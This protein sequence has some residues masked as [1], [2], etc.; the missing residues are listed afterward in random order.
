MSENYLVVATPVFK[1]TLN[2]LRA[3]LK[4]KHGDT[5]AARTCDSIKQ[6]LADL[7]SNPYLAPVS[8]RL[9]ALGFTDYR[10][11]Q[12]DDHNLVFYRV[13][14]QARKVILVIAMDSRQSIEQ[15]LFD[16][17]ISME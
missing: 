7:S 17:I 16:T 15:L 8:D 2:K 1:L 11:F 13:D 9:S 3:F 12:I 6:R 5:L 14:A 4:R 10:Q